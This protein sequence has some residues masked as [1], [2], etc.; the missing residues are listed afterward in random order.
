MMADLPSQIQILESVARQLDPDTQQRQ[1][2]AQAVIDNG[3]AFLESLDS[4]SP[5]IFREQPAKEILD[6][7]PT[8]AATQLEELLPLITRN[9]QQVGLKPASGGYLAY[10]P[11]GGVFPSA[12]GDYLAAVGNHYAGVYYGSP[13]AVRMENQLIRWTAQLLG[14]D[15]EL[16]GGNLASGGSYATL[17]GIHTARSAKQIKAREIENTVIYLSSQTHHAANK[18][19]KVAGLSE[20]I[21]REV[22]LDERF[23]MKPLA[24][25]QM[26]EE[27]IEAGNHPFMLIASLGTTDVGAVDPLDELAD[28]AEEYNLWMHVDA[29]YGGYFALDPAHKALISGVE[30]ADSI[31]IDPHKSLFIALGTGILLVRNRQHLLDANRGSA[32]YLQDFVEDPTE[33][34]PAQLSPELTKHYR[35]LRMWLPLKLFG[36]APFRAALQE[37]R[38]LALW[39]YQQLREIE[40]MEV[41]LEP[42]LT[43]VLF[44]Y[45]GAAS[46]NDFN[47][48]MAAAIQKSG[49]VFLS[50][51]SID[52][53]FYLRLAILHFRAHMEQV[54][55]AVNFIKE[56]IQ[57]HA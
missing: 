1:A 19:I 48:K 30:R 47:R 20:A 39:A 53:Q 6:H 45:V 11:G 29:A 24:L 3:E 25:Q 14:Y 44:R 50:T 4:A 7:P 56:Y 12:L 41:P 27:D 16:A 34:S 10:I 21:L 15:P 9:V 46:P 17:I 5:A 26:I 36:V 32:A 57:Q 37:K 40:G 38:L 54:A 2:W 23:R 51:T 52:G 43:V 28:L 49:K 31:V 42:Q 8:E 35:G 55:Y 18:A 22:P 33:Y 13:G